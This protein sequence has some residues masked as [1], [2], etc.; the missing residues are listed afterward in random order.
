[1]GFRLNIPSIHLAIEP[2]AVPGGMG[3]WGEGNLE[4][5]VRG[6][7]SL[8]TFFGLIDRL[9]ALPTDPTTFDGTQAQRM[10]SAFS[11]FAELI[12]GWNIEGMEPTA[13]NF[14]KLPF[15]LCIAVFSA[16]ASAARLDR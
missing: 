9:G 1:M 2:D 7:V 5:Q 15:P 8:D 16:W 13:D 12:T 6:D 11:D 10:R 3:A 4:V 14:R